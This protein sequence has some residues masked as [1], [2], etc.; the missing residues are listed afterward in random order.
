MS[1]LKDLV[2]TYFYK[3]YPPVVW[4]NKLLPLYDFGYTKTFWN[5][6]VFKRIAAGKAR[7]KN[8]NFESNRTSSMSGKIQTKQS[9]LS[10]KVSSSH[11]KPS[12]QTNTK[13]KLN[14]YIIS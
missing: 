9:L 5:Q 3:P 11:Q 4:I 7:D 6:N 1:W 13:S 2:R 10:S 8:I 14:E 12:Y